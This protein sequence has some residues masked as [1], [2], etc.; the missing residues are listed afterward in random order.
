MEP[1]EFR[2]A[3]CGNVYTKSWSDEEA[4]TE[5]QGD[6]P[7][8]PEAEAAVICDDCYQ[9]VA[10]ATHPVEYLES[11]AEHSLRRLQEQVEQAK[12]EMLKRWKPGG[13]DVL[14]L[15]TP[16]EKAA[17]LNEMFPMFRFTVKEKA[18]SEGGDG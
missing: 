1:N 2:C 12:A 9:K 4:W 3:M 11:L 13:V 5:A 17:I 7:G 14:S 15:K 16:G 18:E 8:L 10:P 6:W